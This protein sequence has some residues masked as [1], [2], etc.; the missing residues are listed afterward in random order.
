MLGG[1]LQ[2]EHLRDA[3]EARV[4]LRLMGELGRLGQRSR[5]FD[6]DRLVFSRLFDSRR[7]SL[8]CRLRLQCD[9]LCRCY[10]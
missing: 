3:L 8:S 10:R 5:D 6:A 4:R 7:L 2:E 9:F 1:L